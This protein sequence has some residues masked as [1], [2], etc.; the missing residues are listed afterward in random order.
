MKRRLSL[1][2]LSLAFTLAVVL[3]SSCKRTCTCYHFTGTVEHFSEE[4]LERYGYSCAN[5]IYFNNG[6]SYS[7][8]E[9][10]L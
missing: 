3:M 7:S 6:T 10:D 1:F 2:L 5:M 8:C 4:D 9:H